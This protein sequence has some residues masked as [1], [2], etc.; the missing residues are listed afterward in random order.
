MDLTEKTIKSQDIFSGR[1]FRVKVDTVKLP[2]GHESI[3]ELVLHH[4]GVAVIAVD[5]AGRVPMVRQYRKAAEELVLEIPAGK[6]EP[7]E[8]PLECG[9]RE[10]REETGLVAESLVHLGEYLPTPGYCSEKI[11]IYLARE[12]SMAEQDLDPDE[13]LDVEY[14]DLDTLVQMVMDNQ[15]RDAK[16][17]I[18][19]LKAEKMLCN[20]ADFAKR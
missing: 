4:G 20:S 12:C 19:I 16:T 7:D 17:A 13:F 8:D 10:L 18:A 6:L 5:D 2:N 15:I 9:K 14:Y 11:N 3:R 1:V